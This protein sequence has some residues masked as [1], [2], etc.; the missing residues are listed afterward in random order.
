MISEVIILDGPLPF[1]IAKKAHQE[2]LEAVPLAEIGS[3]YKKVSVDLEFSLSDLAQKI[4][5]ICSEVYGSDPFEIKKK[6][7]PEDTE[8]DKRIVSL[9]HEYPLPEELGTSPGFWNAFSL[10]YAPSPIWGFRHAMV[11]A[12]V[13][14]FNEQNLVSGHVYEHYYGRQWLRLHMTRDESGEMDLPLALTGTPEFWRSHVFR[15]K[16]VWHPFVVRAFL[17]FQYL[18]GGARRFDEKA[19]SKDSDCQGLR[20]FIKQLAASTSVYSLD[21]M[22][23]VALGQLFEEI[24]VEGN[25]QTLA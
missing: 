12:K 20:L 25:I 15:Q 19:G 5:A 8:F 4:H 23:P 17:S 14:K 6:G 24:T 18:E 21:I 7:L 11:P 9:F 10:M 16:S 2:K 3:D 1:E 13:P 22:D